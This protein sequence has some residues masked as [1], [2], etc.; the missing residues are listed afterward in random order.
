MWHWWKVGC[1]ALTR[2]ENWKKKGKKE[3]EKTIAHSLSTTARMKTIKRKILVLSGK[4]GVG[5]STFSSQLSF[6]LAEDESEVGLMDIDICGPSI[7]RML[8][9][10]V[11]LSLLAS[12][13]GVH[14]M[15]RSLLNPAIILFVM[16]HVYI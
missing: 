6:A 13:L 10:M 4:G 2:A 5:K 8:G 15:I 12:S 14:V 9:L 11:S 3:K 1:E 7:P 16:T